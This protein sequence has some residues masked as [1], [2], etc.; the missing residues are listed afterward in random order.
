MLNGKQRASLRAMANGLDTIF[1]I[2][3]NGITDETVKQLSAALDARELIK[4]RVLENAPYNAK[5]AS[6]LLC[7]KLGADGISCVGYRFVLYR[8]SKTLPKEK[9]ISVK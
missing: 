2:G 6:A 3:K 5:E 9:R 4:V 7:E 8:E 1:Q